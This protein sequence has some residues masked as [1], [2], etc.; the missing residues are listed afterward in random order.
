MSS[1]PAFLYGLRDHVD[2]CALQEDDTIEIGDYSFRCIET[3]G[4]SPG[5]MC[6]YEAE[7]KVLVSGDHILVDITPN[8]SY[9]LEMEDSLKEYLESLDKIYSL[10]VNLV[11]PGHR[12]ICSDHRKRITELQEHHRDRLSEV[13]LALDGREKTAWEIA[14]NISWDIEYSSWEQFPITQKWFA[15]GE[16]TAH[17]HYLVGNGKIRRKIK[18]QKVLYSL[19]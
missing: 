18:N 12:S 15:V 14:P 6:L 7:K 9:W 5:H 17:L 16:T 1:H 3:P 4:H 2:F 10:D 8:I 11:L 13:L 19:G